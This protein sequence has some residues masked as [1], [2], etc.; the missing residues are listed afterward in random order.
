MFKVGCWCLNLGA[1]AAVCIKSNFSW[2][3]L[4]PFHVFTFMLLVI[5]FALRS[6]WEWSK[7]YFYHKTFMA[8]LHRPVKNQNQKYLTVAYLRTLHMIWI[9]FKRKKRKYCDIWNAYHPPLTWSVTQCI[10]FMFHISHH[11]HSNLDQNLTMTEHTL[12]IVRWGLD[13]KVSNSRTD[14]RPKNKNEETKRKE[15]KKRV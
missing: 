2:V 3:D 5:T 11:A 10:M 15:K 12:C 8:I 13:S 1:G 14:K 9:E 4:D 6:K 7:F